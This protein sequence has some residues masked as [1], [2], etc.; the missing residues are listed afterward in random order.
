LDFLDTNFI[1]LI[2][3][4]KFFITENNGVDW[5]YYRNRTTDFQW[6]IPRKIFIVNKDSILFNDANV[7]LIYR[8]DSINFVNTELDINELSITPQPVSDK[9][10][11]NFNNLEYSNAD[12]SIFNNLGIKVFQTQK[13]IISNQDN[14]IELNNLSTGLHFLVLKT[15][16]QTFTKKFIIIRE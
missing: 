7:F 15:G 5:K 11:L 9:L 3:T 4:Q 8:S 2:T 12:I 10:F 13:S 16:S 14:V 6:L 1:I